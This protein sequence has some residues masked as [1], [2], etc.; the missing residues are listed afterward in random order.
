M[1]YSSYP[2]KSQ[3]ISNECVLKVKKNDRIVGNVV[4]LM[5]FI[6]KAICVLWSGRDT[7][8]WCVFFAYRKENFSKNEKCKSGRDWLTKCIWGYNGYLRYRVLPMIQREYGRVPHN[9]EKEEIISDFD[10]KKLKIP[11]IQFGLLKKLCNKES[12]IAR[13]VIDLETN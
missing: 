4:N 8:I 1:K 6:K 11:N 12:S 10:F 5:V 9:T 2:V 7:I 3:N 13:R